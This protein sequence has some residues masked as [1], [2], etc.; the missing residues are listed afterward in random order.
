MI[1][2]VRIKKLCEKIK[3]DGIE[4]ALILKPVNIRYLSGFTGDA[5]FLLITETRV[6]FYTDS[7]YT[8]QAQKEVIEGIEVREHGYP[9]T[10]FMA[11]QIIDLNISTLGIEEKYM[12]VDLYR[13][14]K[15]KFSGTFKSIDSYISNMR[16]I[17]EESE[18]ERIKKAQDIA[19][20]A[21]QYICGFIKPGVTERDIAN[22]IEYYI[23]KNGASGTSFPTI[24]VSGKNGSLPHGQPTNKEIR[25]GEFVTM[26]FGCVYEGYCSDMTRTIAVGNVD[27]EMRKVYNTVLNA[28]ISALENIE[29]NM[30]LKDADNIAREFIKKEGFGQYFGHSLGHGVGLEIHE[31]P[32]VGPRSDGLLLPGAVITVEPGI[33]IPGRFG[34]RIE[35]M[36]FVGENGTIDITKS[37][38]QLIIL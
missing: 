13:E 35:D 14:L 23:K 31:E 11:E 36:I 26:D 24:V 32:G 19:D 28:Q 8:E 37:N 5:G 27:S 4:G 21:F 10:E 12:T 33:Y 30:A 22:E 7:R 2:T 9:V 34:V 1:K 17:K 25:N 3:K 20:K 16:M 6:I 15:E 29:A 18:L 38:K